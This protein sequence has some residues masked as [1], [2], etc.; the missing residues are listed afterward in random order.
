MYYLGRTLIE[1]YEFEEA[2]GLVR[3]ALAGRR[4]LMKPD[5]GQLLETMNVLGMV[6]WNQGGDIAA[7]AEELFQELLKSWDNSKPL[8]TDRLD[9]VSNLGLME[10]SRGDY[11]A[12]ERRYRMLLMDREEA[13]GPSHSHTLT[14][15]LSLSMVLGYQQLYKE[16]EEWNR[17]ALEG[18][19]LDPGRE[20]PTTSL[21]QSTLP[22]ILAKRGKF[23]E[24][25]STI[26]PEITSRE[27]ALG[28]NYPFTLNSMGRLSEICELQ[29][30]YDEALH[31][32]EIAYT[33][34]CYRLGKGHPESL[35][36]EAK[37]VRVRSLAPSQ[38]GDNREKQEGSG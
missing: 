6:L 3:Q 34:C 24:A 25:E 35:G 5:D 29:E 28:P 23:D 10:I 13:H 11:P 20:H 7:E 30:R 4:K 26:R 22:N 16:A 17:K 15:T 9:V 33:R 8:S 12:A 19:K 18:L 36:H 1:L 38:A 21:S 31:I 32:W 27:K 37:V 14:C 2:E